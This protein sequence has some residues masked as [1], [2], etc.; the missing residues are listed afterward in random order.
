M[1]SAQN[2]IAG[3]A[4]LGLG[5]AVIFWGIYSSYSVFTG[6]T[7]APEIFATP[8]V[9]EKAQ[10]AAAD[11]SKIETIDPSKLQNLSPA[12]LKDLQAQQQAQTQAM[13]QNSISEQ[14]DKLV[15]ADLIPKLMNL[16]SWSIFIFILIY[17]GSKISGLGISLLRN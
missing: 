17:A 15:P 14:F 2:K 3:W 4:L 9:S 12:Q 13:V 7:K 8:A 6:K 10:N 11:S 1:D 16:S 5:L